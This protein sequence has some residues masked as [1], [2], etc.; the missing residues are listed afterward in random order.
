[1]KVLITS[2]RYVS[3][4]GEGKSKIFYRHVRARS[5]YIVPGR[6]PKIQIKRAF[7]VAVTKVWKELDEPSLYKALPVDPFLV[8]FLAEHADPN[9]PEVYFEKSSIVYDR[10]PIAHDG[11]GE[12]HDAGVAL[13]LGMGR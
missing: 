7:K 12:A 1:M 4:K 13:S 8:K 6:P 11:A 10:N 2:F 5:G 9:N 3:K